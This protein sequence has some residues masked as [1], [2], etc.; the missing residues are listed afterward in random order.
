MKHCIIKGDSLTSLSFSL[1][2]PQGYR[3]SPD[4]TFI[5]ITL[6]HVHITR[7]KYCKFS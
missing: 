6:K 4:P 3:T 5:I 1:A 2:R 7:A